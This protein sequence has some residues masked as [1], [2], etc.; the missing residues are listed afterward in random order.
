MKR[1]YNNQ[2][3]SSFLEKESLSFTDSVEN[4]RIILLPDENKFFSFANINENKNNNFNF[5]DVIKDFQSSGNSQVN[6][7]SRFFL[8]LFIVLISSLL[9]F[10]FIKYSIDWVNFFLF[11]FILKIFDYFN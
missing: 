6:R 3:Y 5:L 10:L 11:F 8:A 2:K 4:S 9:C 7:L 1:I